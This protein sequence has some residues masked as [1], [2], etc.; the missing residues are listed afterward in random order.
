M[1]AEFTL[2]W[3]NQ[4]RD[5]LVVRLVQRHFSDFVGE[6]VRADG[7]ESLS[8]KDQLFGRQ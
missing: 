4:S 1:I 2:R 7:G 5:K 6:F 8:R 3:T